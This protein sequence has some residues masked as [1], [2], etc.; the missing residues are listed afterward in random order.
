ML[1]LENI[2]KGIRLNGVAPDGPVKIISVEKSGENAVTIIYKDNQGRL[3]ESML[4]RADESSLS[5]AEHELPWAFDAP[6]GAFKLGVE[7][8]RIHLAHLFDPMMAIHTSNVEPLPHQITAVYESM[9]PRHPLRF[10]LADDPGAGKTIMAGL[11]IRELMMRSDAQKILIV[12]PG[13]LVDQWQDELFEKFGLIFDIF[14]REM[15]ETSHSGNPFFDKDC[16][17]ARLDQLSRAEDI[18][19]KLQAVDWDLVVVDEAHKMSASYFGSKLNRTKRFMLGELLSEKARHFLLMTATPHNGKE[20]DFQLFL[21]LL[22]AD[23]FYGKFRDGAHLIDTSDV[24]RRMVKEELLKFDGTPLFPERCAYSASYNLSDLEAA[25]YANVTDYV[26][27]EMNKADNLDGKRKG[28]IGFALTILQRRLA[29]SPEAIYKSLK[30]RRGRLEQRI[31]EEKFQQH[32][33]CIAETLATYGTAENYDDIDEEL[34]GT[35]Y[36]ELADKLVD[37]ATAAQTV[38]EL[39]DEIESLKILEFQALQLVNSGQDRKWEELSNLL[40]DNPYMKDENDIRRKLIIFTEHKD[41]LNYLCERIRSLLG[42]QE[43]VVFIH[44]GVNRDE[45]RKVQEIFRNDPGVL[46]LVATDAAG[47]GVNLQNA[48][49]MVNYDLPWNPNRIEQRFGRIHRIGQTEVCHMWNVVAKGTRE[50]DVFQRLL[51]KLEIERQALGGRVFDILGEAFDNRSLKDMLIEAIRY[52]DDPAVRARLEQ[53][54]EGALDTERL[55]E[56]MIRNALS[57]IVMTPERLYAVKA[58]ME[59]AEARKLQPFFIRSFFMEAFSNM[60]GIL[61]GRE[62]GRFEIN[63]VPGIIRERER[64]ISRT[65]DLV[66]KRYERICFERQYIRV[67]NKPMAS[68]IHPGHPLMAAVTD[69]T[70]ETHRNTLTQGAIL[71]DPTDEGSE[72]R[73]LVLIDHSIRESVYGQDDRRVTSRRLQFVEIYPDGTKISAGW[74]PHLDLIPLAS[75]EAEL[76]KDIC[77]A[78]WIG[79]DVETRALEYAVNHLVPDHYNEVKQRRE[80]EITKTQNAVHDRLTKEIA[81]WQDRYLYLKDA[82]NAGKQPRMQPENARR[83]AEDLRARL[84]IRTKDLQAKRN[85]ISSPPLVVSACLVIP[86]GLLARKKGEQPKSTFAADPYRRKEIETIAMH[87]VIAKEK[88]HGYITRDVSADKCGWDISAYKEGHPDRHIEVKGR[89]KEATTLTISRNEILY[90]LNQEEKFRLAIVLVDEDDSVDGPYYI[91]KPFSKEPDWGVASVN[92]DL[93]DLLQ[94]GEEF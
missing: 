14:S 68:L 52:G 75:E 1:S 82:L 88:K 63:H 69:L 86:A 43:P 18:K 47:E 13:G 23:R 10:L 45:R 36:E 12:T 8:F 5:T 34:T 46:V 87:A 26:T 89:A 78:D 49:L 57:E 92:Y 65:R 30:R 31:E 28:T 37:Q 32:G 66:L 3:G 73:L 84:E 19:E 80:D 77:N 79:G 17:I 51:D 94:K 70:I 2:T 91:R 90:G 93:K 38:K 7:A 21:S 6:G 85:L 33:P 35:E 40:Q 62:E 53:Q 41:T 25:L 9:L 56:I 74:A 55:K 72:A 61:R 27:N 39:Q 58:E 15:M 44:G 83:R 81:Y 60:H 76:V 29:S 50:G 16:L 48:N 54:V 11:Y 71:L 4:F 24:M 20:T 64:I 42:S 22:D 59:K 67:F